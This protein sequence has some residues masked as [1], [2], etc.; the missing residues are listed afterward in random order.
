MRKINQ[1]LACLL[2][3]FLCAVP[4]FPLPASAQENAAVQPVQPTARPTQP[5]QPAARP[6]QPVQPV[7]PGGPWRRTVRDRGS[8]YNPLTDNLQRGSRQNTQTQA[9]DMTSASDGPVITDQTEP[10]EDK[11]V[12]KWKQVEGASGYEIFRSQKETGTYTKI[13]S[14]SGAAAVEWTDENL[15]KGE[16]YYYKIRAYRESGGKKTYG[17]FSNIYKK[18]KAGWVYKDNKKL[19]YNS[20]GKLVTDVSGLIGEQS[21]YVL[22]VNKQ[23]NVVTVYAKDDGTDSLITVKAFICAAGE[24]TPTGTFYTPQKYRWLLLVGPC[25][26]QWCTGIQGDILFHSS[27]YKTQDN[28]DLDIAEYNKLGTTCSHGCVRLKAGDAKWIYDNCAIN[29]QVVIYSSSDP[30]PLGKPVAEQLDSFHTW[31]PTDPNMSSE[32]QK[33]HCH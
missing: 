12:L 17:K 7:Q 10:Y 25:Y 2:T 11:I 22:M 29:T 18:G 4:L 24:D 19:Y 9:A 16:T 32:C 15:K 5:V 30:G 27:P 33:R 31:D 14:I 26:G 1:G 28:K 20:Q 21:S 3:A 23:E 6:T 13:K 8:F